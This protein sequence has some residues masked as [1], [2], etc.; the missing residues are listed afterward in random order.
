M[1]VDQYKVIA[2]SGTRFHPFRHSAYFAPFGLFLP[3]LWFL[4]VFLWAR[5]LA[6]G[7]VADS[8]IYLRTIDR[9][10][11]G[12]F[13]LPGFTAAIPL[14]QILYGTLWSR[15]FGLNYVS[16]DCSVALL[17]IGGAMLFYRLARRCNA[18]A[19]G[20]AL[21]SALLMANPCYLFLSFSF[22]SDVPFLALLIS[23]HLT[24]AWCTESRTAAWL[25]AAL[26]VVAFM[27]RPF[28]LASVAG[29]AAVTMLAQRPGASVSEAAGRLL[30]FAVAAIACAIIW[31]CIIELAPVPWM[32]QLKANRLKFLY[33]VPVRVYFLDAFAAPLLYLG[34]V[35]SPLAIPQLVSPR[36]RLGLIIAGALAAVVLP[37]LL[38]DPRASSIPELSCCGGWDNVMVL[39]GPPRFAWTDGRIRALVLAVSI[40]GAAGLLLAG[41][42]IGAVSPGFLAVIISAAIYWAGIVP[43]WMFNDRYYLVMVAAGCL[44]LALAPPPRLA[45]RA[46]ALA[47]LAAIGWFSAAGVHDQQRGLDAVMSVRD[48]LIRRGVARSAIDAGYPLNG[49]DLYRNPPPGGRETDAMES[50]IPLITTLQFKPYTIAVEP[51][52]GAEII[53]RSHWPG[54]FGFG[55]R[56]L[57]LLRTRD[58]SASP[59]LWQQ[60]SQA[61]NPAAPAVTMKIASLGSMVLMMLAP[62]IAVI[63]CFVP[64][65]FP[66]VQPN[67]CARDEAGSTG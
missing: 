35:L 42:E 6:N 17:G 40:L 50:G 58:F 39:R 29:C 24:F 13:A 53:E 41:T 15:L 45:G 11:A 66:P 4:A 49:N 8:W 36:W 60:T 21:A 22:M 67:E 9:W 16:L 65:S 7:P 46:T 18:T 19:Q 26:L 52:P 27:V 43:L 48:G 34:L 56:P 10:N 3:V 38:T 55:R 47:M 31:L 59:P 54:I 51:L 12:I 25:C 14:A 62:L 2:E 23:A 33:L 20:A 64:R 44:L 5:P 28:A 37:L 30:P 57:Y 1:P 63:A 61:G 32:L